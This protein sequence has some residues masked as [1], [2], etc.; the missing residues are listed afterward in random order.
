[1][2]PF[3]EYAALTWPQ[4]AKLLAGLS[5]TWAVAIFA[6]HAMAAVLR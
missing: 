5:A 2:W 6:S 4:R 3:D 1:M